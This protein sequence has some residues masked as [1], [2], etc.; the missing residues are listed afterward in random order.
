[1][2]SSINSFKF[3]TPELLPRCIVAHDLELH[4]LRYTN[5]SQSSARSVRFINH[6]RPRN[7]TLIGVRIFCCFS[8]LDNEEK[9]AASD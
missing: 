9:D 8:F 2:K 4:A 6:W 1:M 5:C 7:G 3:L